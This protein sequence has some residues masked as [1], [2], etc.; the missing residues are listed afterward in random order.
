MSE[1]IEVFKDPAHC[2]VFFDFEASSLSPKSWPIEVGIAWLEGR[3]VEIRSKLIRPHGSWEL[4]DWAEVSA[5]IH[6]I[7][8]NDLQHAEP[9]EDVA[10]W[11]I[12]SVGDRTLVSDATKFDQRWLDHKA[13]KVRPSAP[14]ADFGRA[15]PPNFAFALYRSEICRLCSK[16]EFFNTIGGDRTFAAPII[17]ICTGLF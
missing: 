1:I 14:E 11:L 16:S 5:A 7:P 8:F 6:N 17:K 13:C 4:G 15:A 9:T 12:G 3:R 2:P 10:R